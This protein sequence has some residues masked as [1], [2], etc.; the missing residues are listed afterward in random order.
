MPIPTSINQT[1]AVAVEKHAK[2]VIKLLLPCPVLLDP[3][4]LFQIFCRGL[5]FKKLPPTH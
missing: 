3:Y 1:L 5:Y 4:T 2:V